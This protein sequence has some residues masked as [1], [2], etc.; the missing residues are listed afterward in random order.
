[1]MQPIDFC[2]GSNNCTCAPHL[3][4][5]EI[6]EVI[7]IANKWYRAKH[8]KVLMGYLF[9]YFLKDCDEYDLGT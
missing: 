8:T 9:Y 6:L 4:L 5:N 2:T 1:M 3:A 7:F